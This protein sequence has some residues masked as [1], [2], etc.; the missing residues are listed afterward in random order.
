MSIFKAYL[1][2]IC[3]ELTLGILSSDK[4][5]CFKKMSIIIQRIYLYGITAEVKKLLFK[6]A[7]LRKIKGSPVFRICE[8]QGAQYVF[9]EKNKIF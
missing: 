7:L 6:A 2:G 5:L 4:D 1:N 9:Y 3:S 8:M